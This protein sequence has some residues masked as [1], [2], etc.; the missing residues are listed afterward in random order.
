MK[1][2]GVFAALL[3]G[4]V[5][6][7]ACAQDNA[8]TLAK[9]LSNPV[10]SLI[11]V[12]LQFN[13]D[14]SYGELDGYRFTL[15]VQPVIPSSLNEDWNLITRVIM[16]V[17]YQDDVIGRSSQSGLGDT[18]PTFFFS[19]KSSPGGLI[20]AI[21]PVFLLPT[22]TDDLL[23]TEKW[24]AGP[25]ALVLK[26]TTTG[27]TMGA[28]VN[29]IESFA[30]SDDRAD[31]SNTFI[32]PFF[33]KQF[34]G[35]RTL[36]FNSESTYDWENEQWTVPINVMYSKVTKLG[37]QMISFAGGARWYAETPDGGPEWGARFVVTLLY[38]GK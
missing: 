1:A 24:G 11:S 12:P 23:G 5:A 13:Y 8:D 9:Q 34:K 20:W 30:G 14:E 33:A 21:G 38:P 2:S 3:P 17:I 22:A 6:C 4:I 31:I 18:T 25:S 7:A 28:L 10:A 35:G 26:Q 16:P 27:W 37:G 15:N 19:P 29:H 36:T 32:Q